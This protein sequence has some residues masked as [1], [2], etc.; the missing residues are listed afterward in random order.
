MIRYRPVFDLEDDFDG[1]KKRAILI[2]SIRFH[3]GF[4]V[5]MSIPVR[6]DIEQ[7]VGPVFVRA[8]AGDPEIAGLDHRRRPFGEVWLIRLE[9]GQVHLGGLFVAK[10]QHPH[11]SAGTDDAHFTRR[12]IPEP[13]LLGRGWYCENQH[14]DPYDDLDISSVYYFSSLQLGPLIECRRISPY[15]IKLRREFQ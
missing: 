1:A 8:I 7:I 5:E 2:R 13:L 4:V 6:V 3:D 14:D 15:L 10:L 11:V 9:L 12:V